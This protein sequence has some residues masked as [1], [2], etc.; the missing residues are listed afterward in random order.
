MARASM[1]ETWDETSRFVRA[2][3][4]LLFPL[5][6][7]T[8]GL[9]IALLGLLVP[10]L[11]PGS[12]PPGTTLLA[13][14]PMIGLMLLGQLAI[15]IAALVAGASVGEMLA[16]AFRRLPVAL[17]ANMLVGLAIAAALVVA[18]LVVALIGL[19]MGA[20]RAMLANLGVLIALP[21]V[22][23]VAVRTLPL[24]PAIAVMP[25][26]FNPLPPLKEAFRL[27]RGHAGR[28]AVM[29]V[30]FSLAYSIVTVAL[31]LAL[32]SVFRIVAGAIGSP[33]L[34]SALTA[35]AVA[36]ASAVMLMI[37]TVFVA[38]LYRRLQPR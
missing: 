16:G 25:P 10:P 9:A 30:L 27:T 28:I 7:A 1:S 21:A 31:Q 26:T 37:W 14:V 5:A 19:V 11:Q 33:A 24:L 2:E 12:A 23:W 17:L 8:I 4:G 3:G 20:S 6:A 32:G 36:L 29:W 13:L 15:S 18:M 38:R 22:L 34:G 35:L